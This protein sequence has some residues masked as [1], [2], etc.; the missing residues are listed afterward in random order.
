MFCSKISSCE[1]SK[2]K[3]NDV[4]NSHNYNIHK[5]EK[6][7]WNTAW[8]ILHVQYHV[9]T[10]DSWSFGLSASVEVDGWFASVSVFSSAASAAS[11][12]TA[13]ASALASVV[14]AAAAASSSSA[15]SFSMSSDSAPSSSPSPVPSVTTSQLNT[16]CY[17]VP[18]FTMAHRIL[19]LA[20]EL[21]VL[22]W[23]WTE[24]W[25]VFFQR[26]WSNF[27]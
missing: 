11:A 26:K 15:S 20:A 14:S 3:F 23:K 17:L 13:A 19:S 8:K 18:E 27:L 1:D 12:A 6:K 21:V 24:P 7:T 2:N 16:T 5:L 25:S 10:A 22:M 4:Q 9:L